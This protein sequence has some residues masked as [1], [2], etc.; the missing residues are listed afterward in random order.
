MIAKADEL[1]ESLLG[2]LDPIT[3]GFYCEASDFELVFLFAFYFFSSS[4]CGLYGLLVR[5]LP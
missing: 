3:A 2:L 5:F 1:I 4:F